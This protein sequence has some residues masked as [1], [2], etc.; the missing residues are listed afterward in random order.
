MI[1]YTPANQLS[2][3]CFTT[4]FENTLSPDNRWVKLSQIIPWD[5]L[6][7]IYM[8][9]LSSTSG[10]ES[11][12]VRMVIAALIIKHKLGL[13]DR[14]TVDMISENIYLQYFCGLSSFQT[15]KPFHPTVFVDIRKRMGATSFDKW[16]EIIIEKADEIKPENKRQ[17]TKNNTDVS[18]N[19][20]NISNKE[21]VKKPNKG[22]LKIDA[23][24][25]NQKIVYPT[26]AGLLNTARKESE[27]IIDL[28]YAQ[29]N[30]TKK[31]RTYRRTA[32]TEYLNFSKNRRKSKKIIKKFIRKQLGYLKRNLSYIEQLLDNI[33]TIKSKENNTNLQ[34][35]F[36]L[37]HRDQKIYWVLQHIYEQQKYMY[38]SHTHSVKDRIVNLYQPYVRPIQRGKDKAATEFGA[39]IS[40][41]E[42]DGMSRVERISW[43]NFNESTDLDLQTEMFKKTFGHYPELLL[44]DQIYLNRKNRNIL[45]M[46][47]I[48]IV[49]KPLG[50]PKKEKLSACQKRKLKK[51]RNQRNLIEGKFGQGKN[52]YGL[53]N[54]KAK[55][56]DTSES[57]ISA[58]FFIMNLITL[59]KVAEKYAF[60][61]AFIENMFSKLYFSILNF[62]KIQIRIFDLYFCD[63]KIKKSEISCF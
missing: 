8:K 29:S 44:A 58:V 55:R 56:S 17:I 38:D 13:D 4:P 21:D 24:V 7:S 23:T 50:R 28:L 59:S 6:A 34:V 25:A 31:P 46:K 49:G 53:S 15:E 36:P 33:E 48:R 27:R 9:Q 43:D 18:D 60:F 35:L 14:G 45:K 51:E 30:Y 37:S 52:A 19:E 47:G 12:D 26:D 54:I 1:K 10:R 2:L 39:K 11:I 32:R 63:E 20:R 41:S 22:I 5:N 57:W 40:A 3:N 16:N 62:T 42:V 61:C